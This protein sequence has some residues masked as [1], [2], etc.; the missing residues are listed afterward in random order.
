[1]I[2]VMEPSVP[3]QNPRSRNLGPQNKST[4]TPKRYNR[5][6]MMG[7]GTLILRTQIP[8]RRPLGENLI[9]PRQEYVSSSRFLLQ[10]HPGGNAKRTWDFRSGFESPDLNNLNRPILKIGDPRGL[11][12]NI[13]IPWAPLLR[14]ICARS[15]PLQFEDPTVTFGPTS[16][17]SLSSCGRT[18]NRDLRLLQV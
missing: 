12:I 10:R 2:A 8:E 14:S 11:V 15:G 17:R 13:H 4:P 6:I 5:D 1:M 7:G 3:F 18:E 9:S 16:S